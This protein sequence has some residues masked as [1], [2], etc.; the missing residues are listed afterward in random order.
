MNGKGTFIWPD[1]RIYVG[2]YLE[3]KKE[4]FGVYTFSQ[5]QK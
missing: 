1:G 2:D 4:G 3:D 5:G